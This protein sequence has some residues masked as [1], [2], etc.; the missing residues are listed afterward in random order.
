M[1][2]KEGAQWILITIYVMGWIGAFTA[3]FNNADRVPST[4]ARVTGAAILSTI[5]PALYVTSAVYTQ[6][7]RGGV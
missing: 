1:R 4:A 5:W 7:T 2:L 3:I 6:L